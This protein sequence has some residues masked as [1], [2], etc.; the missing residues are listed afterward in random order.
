MS[1][2]IDGMDQKKSTLPIRPK[3]VGKAGQT[4]NHNTVIV[5]SSGG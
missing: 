3:G 4:N 1:V 5:N 2:L